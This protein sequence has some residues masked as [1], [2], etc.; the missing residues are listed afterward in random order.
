[1]GIGPQLRTTEPLPELPKRDLDTL[2]GHSRFGTN[3][4]PRVSII[5]V[6]DLEE[7]PFRNPAL[8]T[9]HTL[10]GISPSG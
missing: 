2:Q 4:P 7:H 5:F 8:S 9:P 10:T 1:M 6:E 3:Q